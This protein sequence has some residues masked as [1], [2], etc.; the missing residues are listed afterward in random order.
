MDTNPLTASMDNVLA[1]R[2]GEIAKRAGDPKRT[3]VG[4][5]IDRG[6]ILRK[7]LEDKGFEIRANRGPKSMLRQWMICLLVTGCVTAGASGT[8]TDRRGSS[9]DES[10]SDQKVGSFSQNHL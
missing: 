8:K 4:D 10:A 2:L 6:L 3:D 9:P 7:P 1:W 5:P